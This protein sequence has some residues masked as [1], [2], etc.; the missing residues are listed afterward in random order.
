M[1]HCRICNHPTETFL[2][3][4]PMPLA[5]AFL[6]PEDFLREHFYSLR[7][8]FCPSCGMVQIADNPDPEDMFHGDYAY[9]SGQSRYMVQHFQ[10]FAHSVRDTLGLGPKDLVVEIGS[11]DGTMLTN[12]ASAGF[13][14]L[15]IEPSGNVADVARAKGVETLVTFFNR[16][17]ALAVREQQGPAAAIIG[18][19]VV[20]HIPDM[21]SVAAGIKALLAPDGSFVFEAP[22]LASMIVNGAY[23]QIYDEHIYFLSASTVAHVFG[24]YGLTLVD[25]QEQWVHGGSLRFWLRHSEGARISDAVARQLA[26]ETRLGLG[27]TKTYDAFRRR[28]EKSR[29]QLRQVVGDARAAGKRVVGYGATAKG[30]IVLNYCGLTPEMIEFVSDTTPAKQ[31]KFTPGTH[32]PVLPH[33]AFAAD[34]PDYAVLFAW[35]HREEILAKESQYAAKGG[36]WIF[37]VP[38]VHVL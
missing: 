8:A 25:V 11:N 10:G 37:Y 31:Y 19:N 24:L 34:Y 33:G 23:D 3:L 15:G 29:D 20:A 36:K 5:N 30:T 12:F 1:H 27:E 13:R 2:D 17:T 14:H 6:L 26:K 38:D 4:G 35:N 7:A 16:E 9:F 32:I 28:C 21:H 22:D 18:A